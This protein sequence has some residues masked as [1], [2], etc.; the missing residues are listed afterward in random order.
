MS[1]FPLLAFAFLLLGLA[2]TRAA[3]DP[4]AAV[5]RADAARIA[6]TI[7]GDVAHLAP[8]LSEDLAYGQ[9]DGRVQTK[10]Q[11]ITAVAT[12]RVRYESCDYSDTKLFE[13]APEV[14]T[15]TGRAQIRATANAQPVTFH[16]RFLAVWRREE[17]GHWRLIA[18]QSAPL[19]DA[20][21]P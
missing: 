16:L 2:A 9:A 15:M 1:R 19:A 17:D 8:L 11:F 18:Y 7:A 10:A 12:N 13:V 14:I 4:F 5:K 20:A 6:A 3:V 21:A